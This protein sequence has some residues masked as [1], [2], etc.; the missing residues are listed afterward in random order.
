MSVTGSPVLSMSMKV[1]TVMHTAASI[2]RYWR[3]LIVF[4]QIFLRELIVGIS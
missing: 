2:G 1:A 3:L 4:F